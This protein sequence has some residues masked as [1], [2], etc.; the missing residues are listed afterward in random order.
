MATAR[1]R[2]AALNSSCPDPSNSFDRPPANTAR[3]QA[4]IHAA[5]YA[6]SDPQA[7]ARGRRA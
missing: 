3:M 2:I 6:Q 7:A 4:P 1:I 5:Q